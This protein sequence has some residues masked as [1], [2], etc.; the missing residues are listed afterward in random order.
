MR[1]VQFS[2]AAA[3]VFSVLA[4]APCEAQTASPNERHEVPPLAKDLPRNFEEADSIFKERIQSRFPVGTPERDVVETLVSQ[5]F[6]IAPKRNMASFEE[7]STVC[8]LVWRVFW[9]A[10]ADHNLVEINA[11]YGGLC[12]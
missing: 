12:L 11:V 10:D 2:L 3:V 4:G 6:S 1:S 8:R 9:K 5:G 7:P